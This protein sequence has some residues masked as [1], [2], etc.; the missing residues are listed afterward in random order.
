MRFASSNLKGLADG[1]SPQYSC[2]FTSE[3]P[4]LMVVWLRLD[5]LLCLGRFFMLR[6]ALHILVIHLTTDMKKTNLNS[7][8]HS[9]LHESPN[10]S[11]IS[12]SMPSNS[13]NFLV[14]RQWSWI[15]N[16]WWEYCWI[17]CMS[18]I[19]WGFLFWRFSVL[20]RFWIKLL[21]DG[22]TSK[23]S[24]LTIS[25]YRSK[26]HIKPATG[27]TCSSGSSVRWCKSR[28]WGWDMVIT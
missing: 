8:D 20:C 14:T 6:R 25:V 23:I 9:A 26:N 22:W 13:S 19:L 10:D 24:P 17:A 18:I 15:L 7:T 4:D 28:I 16:P 3:R 2:E 5:S 21:W 12:G 1:T 11:A 27:S